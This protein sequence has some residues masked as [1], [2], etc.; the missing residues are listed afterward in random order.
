VPVGERR[1]RLVGLQDILP[2]LAAMTGCPLD[3]EVHGLDL[4]AALQSDKAPTRELFYSQ[5]IDAP[6]QS[7]MVFDG[8]TK[9]CWAQEGPNEELYDLAEDPQELVNLASGPDGEA[10][11]R[12]WRERLIAEAR[13]VGDTGILDADGLVTAPLDREAI[14]KLPVS[15]MGWRWF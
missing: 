4:S 1:Q 2:S 3:Q 12:P 8:R 13:K 10:L 5:C 15:G 14:E 7:A 6:R 9:Y 11:C